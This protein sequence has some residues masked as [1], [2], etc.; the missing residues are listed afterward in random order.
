MIFSACI[1]LLF[2]L[3]ACA[4]TKPSP[5]VSRAPDT[6]LANLQRAAAL[7]WTDDGWC[8][9]QYASGPWATVVERCF[10][11]LDTSRV[12]FHDTERRC[13]VASTDAA[14][15][16]VM[17][18]M[19]LLV[20]PQIVV[21][22]VIVIGAVVVAVA[23]HEEL[24]AYQL[25]GSTPK[26]TGPTAVTKPVAEPASPEPTD[27]PAPDPRT[28][29]PRKDPPIFI[30]DGTKRIRCVPYPVPHRGGNALHNRCAD[31]VPLNGLA[32]ADVML[33][34]KHFDAV[35]FGTRTLWE[36]KTDNFDSYAELFQRFVA[37]KQVQELLRERDLARA[38]GFDFRIGVR[39]AQHKAALIAE[40]PELEELIVVMD[41]C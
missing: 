9:V 17:V 10:H 38:C 30:D 6:R 29:P 14:S 35:Q 15:L 39:S 16:Q 23:I 40:K 1:A 4:T 25:R 13:P 32:G 20:Q 22:A 41:W 11:A 34:G 12:R 5:E 37:E 18:G 21:G 31:A 19:C 24:K 33:D 28:S 8:V 7:P 2:L 27:D 36:V 3:S 26:K